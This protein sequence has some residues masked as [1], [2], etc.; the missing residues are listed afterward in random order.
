MFYVLVNHHYSWLRLHHLGF[1]RPFLDVTF[2]TTLATLLSFLFIIL[3][4]PRTIRWLRRMK[5]GDLP[6]FDQDAMNALMSGKRGT[7]TMGGILIV[8][9]IGI[10][11]FLL[12]DLDIFY[13]R[14]ALICLFWLG[15]V[16]AVD[17][18]LKLTT[19]SRAVAKGLPPG[20]TAG[21]QGLTSLEK[22]LFQIGLSVIL[23]HF[24]YTYSDLEPSRTLYF[25]F[26]K[27]F[28][29]YLSEPAFIVIAVL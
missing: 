12:A 18:W 28:H 9:A 6:N 26:F 10:T 24:T 14:M 16:G 29:I 7:P 17:D 22:I 19:H 21:R 8:F 27:Q 25:P 11:V 3:L 20:A 15:A 4:G 5:I 13:V 23:G 2:Q 1:S